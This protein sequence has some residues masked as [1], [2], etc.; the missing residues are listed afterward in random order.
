M[1]PIS[2]FK[3][4]TNFISKNIWQFVSVILGIVLSVA[5]I[6]AT[7]VAIHSAKKSFQLSTE[8]INGKASHHLISNSHK[9][10]ESVLKELYADEQITVT[11]IIEDY[12][13][14]DG[15]LLKII[16]F[17]PFSDYEF[18]TI[19]SDLNIKKFDISPFINNLE[20]FLCSKYT[21]QKLKIQSG[22]ILEIPTSRGLYPLKLYGLIN[23]KD[24]ELYSSLD[25]FLF[26]DISTAQELL[27]MDSYISRIDLIVPDQYI[28][29]LQ[30]NL[31]KLDKSL[32]LIS[33]SD[34]NESKESM[35]KSFNTNL[36]AL[37]L[38][39]TLVGVFLIYNTM[40]FSILQRRKILAIFRSVGVK[41]HEIF[42]LVLTESVILAVLGT[43]LGLVLG[44]STAKI[45]LDLITRTINDLYF[46]IQV[47]QI[48]LN[49]Y[50]LLKPAFIGV[51]ISILSALLPA[52]EASNIPVANAI[53]DIDIEEKTKNF[54]PQLNLVALVCILLAFVIFALFEKSIALCFFGLFI[55]VFGCALFIPC[56]VF[57]SDIFLKL[58]FKKFF[59]I[60]SMISIR[61]LQKNLSRN[62][63]AIAALSVSLSLYLSL[64]I[65]ISSFRSTVEDWLNYSLFADVYISAPKL[66]ANK[67]NQ[68]LDKSIVTFSKGLKDI[69][70]SAI[71]E[72]HLRDIRTSS[73]EE[74]VRLASINSLTK[75]KESFRFKSFPEGISKDDFIKSVWTK[76]ESKQGLL[77]SAPYAYKHKIKVG[78]KVELYTSSGIES[79]EI[80]AIFNDY[81]S[82]QGL[83]IMH[84]DWYRDLWQD[85]EV[86][87][88][89][90]FLNDDNKAKFKDQDFI[91]NFKSIALEKS[92]AADKFEIRSN[93]QLKDESMVIFDRTFR[94]TSVLK[95][96]AI[97]V[98]AFGIFNALQALLIERKKE[99][100]LL[101]AM[102][103]SNFGIFQSNSLQAISM[104]LLSWLYSIPIGIL[105]AWVM[106]D[107]INH[108]SFGWDIHFGLNINNFLFALLVSLGCAFL[109]SLYPSYQLKKIS[110]G[111]LLKD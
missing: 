64:D 35:T 39:A 68:S 2:L 111:I 106:I 3:S 54:I 94:I 7:D 72:Y 69:G 47:N 6:T 99:F 24:E 98:A 107:V 90:I 88:I 1:L 46:V 30:E 31:V 77:A 75:V 91:S 8:L 102:G 97:I 80:L 42:T 109:A 48:N 26:M 4:S 67:N 85:Y 57:N 62:A 34:R 41:K 84:Q 17:D 104:G 25:N 60:S 12:L 100:A 65:A 20:A 29:K 51:F 10:P 92:I 37:S 15:E 59:G 19:T 58:I 74:T 21:A 43:A 61:S 63:I 32:I 16:G 95:I 66:V 105:S 53:K 9:I 5:I 76:F 70:Q 86:S 87:S 108:R 23:N 79:F 44:L 33:S 82:D 22:D 93:Q 81:S 52:Y 38:L 13:S 110:A 89:G 101:K 18:R 40:S 71:S 50:E 78:D 36:S 103:L 55:M 11:P 45:I 83:L 96:I 49:Y 14:K 73:T 56:L 27:Q 28:T